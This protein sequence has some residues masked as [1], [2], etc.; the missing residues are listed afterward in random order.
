VFLSGIGA[1][2][3]VLTVATNTMLGGMAYKL[4]HVTF[5][6]FFWWFALGIGWYLVGLD[7]FRLTWPRCLLAASAYE[8]LGFFSG[9]VF[10]RMLMG[11]ALS[12]VI[13][14]VGERGPLAFMW[15]TSHVGD[16][17]DG[18]YIWHMIVVNTF[19]WFGLQNVL[20]SLL[21]VPAVILVSLILAW[22]SWRLVEKT[23]LARKRVSSRA[24]QDSGHGLAVTTA[25]V[26][27]P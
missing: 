2:A 16:L 26:R 5:L 27:A 15:F 1:V 14:C 11:V 10:S 6:P 19:L 8:G 24:R 9:G 25:A 3:A 12:Y 21:V 22:L 20:P 17:S 7:R 23:C 18:T 13:V 4:V